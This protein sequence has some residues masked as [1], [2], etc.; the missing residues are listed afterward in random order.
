MDKL[1]I[2]KKII[3]KNYSYA[4]CGIFNTR[5][6]V[7]DG[8]TNIYDDDGLIIDVCYYYEYF[9]VFGL[10]DDE[11]DELENYYEELRGW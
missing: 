6:L 2:A 7:G 3:F 4:K 8:M 10:S 1:E 11:F 9:E 5:N